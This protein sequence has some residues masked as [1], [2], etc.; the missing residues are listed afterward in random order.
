MAGTGQGEAALGRPELFRQL[1]ITTT[2][3]PEHDGPIAGLS[4]NGQFLGWM[5]L[6]DSIKPE[7]RQ[8]LSELK[9]TA[10]WKH[11]I[12]HHGIGAGLVQ[13]LAGA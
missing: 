1:Q 4:L 9:A 3:V 13:R 5:L 12:Q 2:A 8:A 11:D 6:A 10:I 7:A